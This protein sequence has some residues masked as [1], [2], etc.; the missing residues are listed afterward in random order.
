MTTLFMRLAVDRFMRLK[1]T[2]F[3]KS[4]RT[5]SMTPCRVSALSF[6]TWFVTELVSVLT[7]R[8]KTKLNTRKIL[9]NT[10]N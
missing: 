10:Q 1:R 2:L 6:T 3:I 8:S 4:F 7:R 9:R 5:F